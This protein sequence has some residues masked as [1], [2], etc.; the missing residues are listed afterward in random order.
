MRCGEDITRVV[1]LWGCGHL[2]SK[3]PCAPAAARFR[4]AN[5]ILRTISPSLF[6]FNIGELDALIVGEAPVPVANHTL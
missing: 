5:H 4:V 2:G 1:G 6:Q 3:P